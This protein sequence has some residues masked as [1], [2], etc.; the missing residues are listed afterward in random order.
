MKD[1]LSPVQQESV[2][3]GISMYVGE[4]VESAQSDAWPIDYFTKSGYS[5]ED[6]PSNL[7]GFYM[8]VRGYSKQTIK[9]LCD[10][11]TPK[12]SREV[13]D[14]SGGLQRGYRAPW[15]MN[16]LSPTAA[17]RNV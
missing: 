10:A 7:I 1:D 17:P 14:Q 5:E 12:Q 16:H 2:A 6:L 4:L 15:V 9:E 11:L 8:G 3:L 13:W